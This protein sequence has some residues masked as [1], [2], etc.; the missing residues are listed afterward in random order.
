MLI[1]EDRPVPSPKEAF[2]LQ[3]KRLATKGVVQVQVPNVATLTCGELQALD[4]N[5]RMCSEIFTEIIA[6]RVIDE[7]RKFVAFAMKSEEK[8][9]DIG[10]HPATSFGSHHHGDFHP[11]LFLKSFCGWNSSGQLLVISSPPRSTTANTTIETTTFNSSST[12]PKMVLKATTSSV[13]F[14]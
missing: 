6:E 10:V 2:K 11:A 1:E 13:I 3:A 5:F 9:F 12:A 14:T 7:D 8:V 4:L